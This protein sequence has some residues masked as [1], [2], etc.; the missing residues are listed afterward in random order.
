MKHAPLLFLLMSVFCADPVSGQQ[1]NGDFRRGD[2]LVDGHVDLADAVHLAELLFNN[3]APFDCED[4]CDANDDG[5]HDVGDLISILS[6]V[7]DFLPLSAPGRNCGPDPTADSFWCDVACWAPVIPAES[8]DHVVR[9]ALQ[10]T[11]INEVILEITMDTP[12]P[13][14]AFSFGICHDPNEL[15]M[16]D[17]TQVVDINQNP[18][19]FLSVALLP[20]GVG[21]SAMM[22]FTNSTVFPAGSDLRLFEIEYEADPAASGFTPVCPCDNLAPF[23]LLPLQLVT[24]SGD[25]VLPSTVCYE[26]MIVDPLFMMRGDCNG[27]FGFNVGDAV[28][29]LTFLF[30]SPVPLPC[31]DACDINDDGTLDLSDPVNYL[32][33]LFAGGPPPAVPNFGSGCGPDPTPGDPLGCSNA[34]C[35]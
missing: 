24:Q 18:P 6:M 12:D 2:C 29:L 31:E 15:T 22:S 35:P 16:G 5:F 25:P 11:P 9:V 1:T 20:D 19:E 23:D 8:P 33:H 34:T 7:L 27:D 10:T 3:P 13:L 28:Y 14:L 32:T 26:P 4:A 21:F 17:V 30:L